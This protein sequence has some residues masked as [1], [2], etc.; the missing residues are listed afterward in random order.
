MPP[1]PTPSLD[2][3]TL[4]WWQART[5]ALPLRMDVFVHEQGVDESEEIDKYDDFSIHLIAIMGGA[6]VGTG[7]LTPQG[8]LG[9]IAVKK[10]HR[11]QG[12]GTAITKALI[13]CARERGLKRVSLLS[14]RHAI[15]LYERCGFSAEEGT[16]MDAGI[17]H[18][19]M[20]L[21]LN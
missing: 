9:R 16:V 21:Q 1:T 2:I 14:Q 19:K 4:E 12:I 7:R 13:D 15:P 8:R 5:L 18:T 6:I 11:K 17:E 3:Q 20:H 10:T